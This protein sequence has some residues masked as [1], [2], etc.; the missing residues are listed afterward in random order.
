MPNTNQNRD[1]VAH[2]DRIAVGG[3]TAFPAWPFVLI[4]ILVA[5]RAIAYLVALISGYWTAPQVQFVP[6]WV[7]FCQAALFAGLGVLLIWSGR[8]DRRAWSLGIFLVDSA[9][10]LMDPYVGRFSD[11]PAVIVFFRQVRPDAF[12]AAM[13]WFFA[14]E[15]PQ[16]ARRGWLTF[17]IT[18]GLVL[19]LALGI[20]LSVLDG[21]VTFGSGARDAGALSELA[22]SVQRHSEMSSDWFFTLQF[23]S[24]AP[25]LVLLPLKFQECDEDERRRFKWLAWGIAVGILPLILEVFFSTAVDG[26]VEATR[27]SPY[28]ETKG[29]LIF[30]ALA[31]LPVVA[32]YAALVQQT[33]QLRV[34]IGLALQYMLARSVVR[35]LGMAPIVLI[36]F[37]VFTN[38]DRSVADLLAGTPG[39]A[40]ALTAVG[41]IGLNV[42]RRRLMWLVDRQ[43]FREP[44]DTKAALISFAEGAREARTTEM[45]ATQVRAAVEHT[46]HAT[47]VAVAIAGRDDALHAEETGTVPLS[48]QSVLAQ[49]ISGTDHPLV[50]EDSALAL[51]SRLRDQDQQ[52]LN[53]TQARLV[54]PLRGSDGNLLGAVAMGPKRGEQDYSAG[55]RAILSA[56][57]VSWGL[58]LER[59]LSWGTGDPLV[60]FAEPPGWECLTCSRIMAPDATECRCGG[61][62][63]RAAV[64]LHLGDRLTFLE[65]I[66][67]GGMG[68]VYK[69]VDNRIRQERAVKTMSRT[70]AGLAARLRQEAQAMAAATHPNL[71]IVHGLEIWRDVP[72]L[73]MEYLPG[74]TLASR[75]RQAPVAPATAISWGLQ[76][77]LALEA[78]HHAGMLHR[79]IKPSNIGFTADGTPKLLDFGLARLIPVDPALASTLSTRADSSASLS[80][81]PAA[82][83]GTP[84]YLSPEILAGGEPCERDDLWSFS[85]TLLEM[86]LGTNPLQGATV[87]A[88]VMRVLAEHQRVADY[89]HKL[90]GNLPRLFRVLLGPYS[91][92]PARARE[93][94]DRLKL[95]TAIPTPKGDA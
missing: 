57:G 61:V 91:S 60:M 28:R 12:Q 79:D 88:T 94:I 51:V 78:V 93:L 65:R 46:F 3:P 53:Q 89:A 67:A 64:P 75:L 41:A 43:F 70:E 22:R 63:Q 74:G 76:L 21:I 80:S 42:W 33:L 87:P 13:L 62:L 18:G 6:Y 84:A 81:D 8:A 71:A 39:A 36:A 83:R 49:L 11:P 48:R 72:L 45:F 50:I 54:V 7:S 44:V 82:I 69:A 95:V 25:L 1:L 5:A 4:G 2:G 38:R 32:A 9:C 37:L 90:P 10:T 66:G 26:Y 77:A 86:C 92:R 24:L 40:I 20:A 30:A 68:V 47:R 19:T 34:A 55:D 58:T 29:A 73:V 23:L 31:I 52:W 17:V 14:S 85:L 16:P 15:F 59:L 27:V 56:A 35:A